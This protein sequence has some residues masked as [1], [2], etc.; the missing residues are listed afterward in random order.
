[1]TTGSLVADLAGHTGVVADVGFTPD[2]SRLL[3]GGHDTSVKEYDTESWEPLRTF[4]GG[5]DSILDLQISADGSVVAISGTNMALVFDLATFEVTDVVSGHH[6][7]VDGVDLSPDSRLLLTAGTGDRSTRLWDI[8]D[9]ASYEL[10]AL[11]GADRALSAGVAFSPDGN[12]LAASRGAGSVTIWDFPGG[13]EVRTLEGPGDVVDVVTYDPA[14][15]Y[16]VAAGTR[17]MTL[18]DNHGVTL[19]QLSEVPVW[20]AAFSPDGQSLVA[21]TDDGAFLWSLSSPGE[22]E[23]L[24]PRVGHAAAFHPDGELVALALDSVES[25]IVEVLNPASG[26]TVAEITHPGGPVWRL[27][28]SPDGRWLATASLDTTAAIWDTVDFELAHTLVGHFD[29]VQ[30]LAFDPIRPEVATSGPDEA[31]KIWSLDTGEELLSLDGL[32]SD[33]AYSPDGSYIA[34][35]GP[36]SSL[37]VHIRSVDELA[38]EAERRLSRWWTDD[39]CR[40]YLSSQTCP[41]S[42]DHLDSD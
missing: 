4:F 12:R 32:Y 2:G 15:Q 26:E 37:I 31:T 21:T 28:F 19:A 33:L 24:S 29:Q 30:T 23:M 41:A 39:E 25:G 36:E 22:P 38:T 34:G 20:D 6:G 5:D 11:P 14:G 40:R 9:E 17:G 35:I 7:A 42:P 3:T 13:R 10:L 18:F 1:M 16:L 8:G 27:D